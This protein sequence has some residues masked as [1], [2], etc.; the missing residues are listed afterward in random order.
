[1]VGT[2][3]DVYIEFHGDRLSSSS[4]QHLLKCENYPDQ[5]FISKHTVR[6]DIQSCLRTFY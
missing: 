4:E 2:S 1:M 5:P 6:K 3:G